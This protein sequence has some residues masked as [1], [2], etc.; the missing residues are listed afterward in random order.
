M[1]W[2]IDPF[3]RVTTGGYM[4]GRFV[5][6]DN[7]YPQYYF[8]LKAVNNETIL[9]SGIY[10][11]KADALL[12]IAFIQ[13]NCHLD[14]RYEHKVSAH[15]SHYFVLKKHDGEVVGTSQLY[16][17]IFFREIGLSMVQLSG[18][19]SNIIDISNSFEKPDSFQ[20]SPLL[21]AQSN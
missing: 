3:I 13:T 12:D 4:R 7:G 16:T 9:S 5:L 17:S 11:S 14:E 18:R 19:T 21:V 2:Q 20:P 10:A 8:V 15:G 6:T 1:A